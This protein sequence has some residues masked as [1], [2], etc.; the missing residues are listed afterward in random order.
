[1]NKD[2]FIK[3]VKKLGILLDEEK[4]N[5]LD[6]FYN[7]LINWNERINLTTITKKEDVYIK[8]FY[9]SLTLIKTIDLKKNLKVLD[10]GT[11]AGFPGIVLKIVFPNLKITLL[12]SLNKRINYLNEIIKELDLKDIETK[13]IRVEDY[14]KSNIEIYDLVVARAVA[15]LGILIETC[16]P[17]VKV[18]G[19]LIAMKA[20]AKEE[21]QESFKILKEI[22]AK[23]V[24]INTFNLPIENSIRT[25][26]KIQK[27][28]KTPNKYPRPYGKIKK[29]YHK[30]EK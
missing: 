24:T 10:V 9:D 14:A 30:Y 18:D 12:D 22:K 16:M 20:N 8:H 13:C 3:E 11:G 21:I 7:L 27:Q 26:I 2:E 17:L 28:E 19:Y 4:L 5:K 25:L 29:E 1:M 23:L 15:H 6:K